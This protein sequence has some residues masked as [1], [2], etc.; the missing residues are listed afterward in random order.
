MLAFWR[1]A[2]LVLS[3]LALT[4]T[5][6][7]VLDLPQKMNYGAEMYAARP[8]ARCQPP[9]TEDDSLHRSTSALGSVL[10]PLAT[11]NCGMV[12]RCGRLW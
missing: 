9:C 6:A 12:L 2:T 1:F 5:S 10:S 7:H 8:E 4:M 3:A 11:R